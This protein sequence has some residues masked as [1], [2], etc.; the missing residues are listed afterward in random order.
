[1]LE[2]KVR[3]HGGTIENLPD[4]AILR[5]KRMPA[6]VRRALEALKAASA[7][8]GAAA[9]V[10]ARA[11]ASAMESTLRVPGERQRW[12]VEVGQ[13]VR[14]EATAL[15]TAHRARTVAAQGL[16]GALVAHETRVDEI[17]A[18]LALEAHARRVDAAVASVEAEAAYYP[19]Q[20]GLVLPDHPLRP[21]HL[22]TTPLGDPLERL[23]WVNTYAL[24]E[25]AGDRCGLVEVEAAEGGVRLLTTTAR[26]AMLVEGSGTVHGTRWQH[27]ENEEGTR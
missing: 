9:A 18:R 26:A 3:N 25:I 7:E 4:R 20:D 16:V 19:A 6:A 8:V 12:L 24:A 14:A 5:H 15:N 2:M 21:D 11:E 17:A 1:M 13:K 22:V 10:H 23:D 27:V